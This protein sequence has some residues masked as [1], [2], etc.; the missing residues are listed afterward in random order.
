MSEIPSDDVLWK[1]NHIR[2]EG[3]CNMFNVHCIRDVADQLGWDDL[4]EWMDE[5][6]FESTYRVNGEVMRRALK[7]AVSENEDYN[8]GAVKLEN[9]SIEFR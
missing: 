9:G 2:R 4:I 1:L 6:V 3:Y 7:L 5:E 8:A